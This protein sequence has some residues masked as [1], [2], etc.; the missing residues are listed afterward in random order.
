MTTAWTVDYLVSDPLA[1]QIADLLD[2]DERDVLQIGLLRCL[3][4]SVR[5]LRQKD[6]DTSQEAVPA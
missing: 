1:A 3:L 2:L 5:Q 6:E 4:R